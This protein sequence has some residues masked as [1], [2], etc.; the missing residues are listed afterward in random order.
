MREWGEVA[1]PSPFC[2]AYYFA[3]R[4]VFAA[5]WRVFAWVLLFVVTGLALIGEEL[6]VEA[7]ARVVAVVVV[8]PDLVVHDLPQLLVAHLA[9]A[10]IEGHARGDIGITRTAP[11][12]ALVELLLVQRVAPL[13]L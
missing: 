9:H 2:I 1:P 5:A 10:A 8:Q 6:S 4:A 12:R 3:V 13:V 11:G 7:D